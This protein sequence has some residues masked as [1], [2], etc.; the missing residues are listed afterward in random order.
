MTRRTVLHGP[1]WGG[2]LASLMPGAAAGE[3]AMAPQSGGDRAALEE[4][5]S[6][7][8]AL[9]DDMG[10]QYTFV[11]IAPVRAQIQTFLRANGRFPE[12]V[13]VGIDVWFQAYDW[14]VRHGQ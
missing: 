10:R 14:H 8:R 13:D 4:V 9:R 7:V 3:P 5:S 11:E 2:M 6:A 12:F 1:L